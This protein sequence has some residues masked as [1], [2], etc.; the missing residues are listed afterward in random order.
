M[1]YALILGIPAALFI[2]TAFKLDD[3][4]AVMRMFFVTWGWI[5]MLPLPVVGMSLSEQAGLSG[6]TKVM[7][8]SLLPMVFGFIIWVF[9]LFILYFRDSMNAAQNPG[10]EF[11][12]EM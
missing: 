4:H 5:M 2:Y 12:N 8:V 11:E 3:R 9:Y 6:I 10:D 7:E 1:N